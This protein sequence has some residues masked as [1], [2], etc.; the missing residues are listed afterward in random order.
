MQRLFL[1]LELLDGDPFDDIWRGLRSSSPKTRASS[2][3]LVENLL[4]SPQRERVL[5]LVGDG[6]R[7]VEAPMSYEEALREILAGDSRTLRVLAEYRA[8]E[9]G[10]DI[11][12]RGS[13]PLGELARAN[14]GESLM[15][16]ARDLF[17]SER[18]VT[19]STRAP[20]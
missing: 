16:R 3:E 17:G 2:L 7:S 18:P 20:A 11:G 13:R 6:P 19:R 8:V 10:L 1:L 9:L 4:E 15:S 5:T 14:I 12:A